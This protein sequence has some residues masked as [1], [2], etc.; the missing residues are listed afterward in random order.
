M[1]ESGKTI[2]EEVV[3][4]LVKDETPP[5]ISAK[6]SYEVEVHQPFQLGKKLL[7]QITWMEILRMYRQYLIIK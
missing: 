1:K 7:L 3:T 4:I 5:V 2:D 6:D